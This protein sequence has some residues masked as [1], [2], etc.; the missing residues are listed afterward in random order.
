MTHGHLQPDA[1][2]YAWVVYNDRRRWASYW[3]QIRQMLAL[4]PKTALIVGDAEGT[5]GDALRRNGVAVTSVDLDLELAPNVVGDVRALP[6]REDAF[7]A[8]L[9]AQVLE[10][11]PFSAF[12]DALRELARVARN[13]V[14]VTLPR[15]GRSW[16]IVLWLPFLP[17]LHVSGKLPARTAHSFDGQSHHWELGARNYPIAEVERRI[18]SVFHIEAKYHVPENP[19]HVFYV[20]RGRT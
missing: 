6:F 7:D 20:L 8:V 5:V 9:C 13:G 3:H 17:R 11:V 2:H 1:S 18:N 14:L 19:F 16:E 12:E 15:K 4:Q 10:H